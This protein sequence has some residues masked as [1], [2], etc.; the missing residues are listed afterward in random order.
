MCLMIHHHTL[1]I[2][3]NESKMNHNY[4]TPMTNRNFSIF[5]YTNTRIYLYT[6]RVSSSMSKKQKERGTQKSYLAYI[7]EVFH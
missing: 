4:T 3:T 7:D 6:K 5:L 1:Q 2:Q